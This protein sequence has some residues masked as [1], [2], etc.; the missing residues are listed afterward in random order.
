[1]AGFSSLHKTPREGRFSWAGFAWV[2]GLAVLALSW[3]LPNH[4]P[5]WATFHSDVLAFAAFFALAIAAAFTSRLPYAVSGAP[6][7]VLGLIAVVLAQL[8]LGLLSFHGDALLAILFLAGLAGSIHAGLRQAAHEEGA[9]KALTGLALALVF[10]GFVSTALALVQWLRLEDHLGIFIANIGETQRPFA[11]FG[12][13]NLFATLLV[14]ALAGLAFLYE[15]KLAGG[16]AAVALGAFLSLG[17]ALAQSRSAYVAMLVTFGWWFAVRGRHSS[18]I[19]VRQA[20]AW[21]ALFCV[22]AAAIGPLSVLLELAG[23]RNTT[24][25][26]NNGRWLMW[27]QVLEGTMQSPWTGYGWGQTAAAQ[28]AGAPGI[29]GKLTTIYAHNV[30]LD[31][32]AWFGIPAGI[33]L[34]LAGVAWTLRRL[35]LA[36]AQVAVY[37]VAAALPV[38]VHS[39]FEFP[40]AYAYFLFPLGLLAGLV[41]GLEPGRRRMPAT[42]ALLAVPAVAWIVLAAWIAVEYVDV[43]EDFRFVRFEA[44]RVGK[45]PDSYVAPH[46]VLNDQMRAMLKVARIN[47]APG[48]S[49]AQIEEVRKVAERFPWA[50]LALRYAMVLEANGRHEAAARQ[51]QVIQGMYGEQFHHS[52][53]ER[54]EGLSGELQSAPGPRQ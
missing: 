44:M 40:F 2:L 8:G 7:A 29:A 24:L 19:T 49:A 25:F 33:A 36:R 47:P 42:G 4:Y 28:M 35:V 50:P 53:M 48:M 30:A 20:L 32:A 26:D 54:M 6:L 12:Q 18:R 43:E 51:M 41:R 34:T 15:R 23:A 13:P 11:N 17:L 52:A 14:M 21:G 22:L 3:L 1:L 16:S 39:C 45:T 31:L 46:L 37:A 10:A 5:P 38:L 27:R 9:I